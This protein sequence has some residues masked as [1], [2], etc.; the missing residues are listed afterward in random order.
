VG[1]LTVAAGATIT[2]TYGTLTLGG[3]SAVPFAVGDV[4]TGSGVVAGTKVSQILTGTG[5]GAGDTVAV[6]NNTVVGST[7]ITASIAVETKFFARSTGLAGEVVKISST[8][9]AG[10]V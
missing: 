2:G 8:T 6:D 7:T 3:V 1:E 4:L 9:N 5:G 10:G